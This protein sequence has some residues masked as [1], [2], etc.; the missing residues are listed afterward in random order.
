MVKEGAAKGMSIKDIRSACRPYIQEPDDGRVYNMVKKEYYKVTR[1]NS[2]GRPVGPDGAARLKK[3]RDG[4]PYAPK[5]PDEIRERSRQK[6]NTSTDPLGNPIGHKPAPSASTGVTSV[7]FRDNGDTLY[8]GFIELLDGKVVTPEA[9]MG[10]CNAAPER[11]VVQSFTVNMWQ[12]MTR[13]GDGNGKMNLWQF[14]IVLR[15]KKDEELTLDEVA[16]AFA[17]LAKTGVTP[18]HLP[19]I[20]TPKQKRKHRM[21]E[22]NLADLH[23]A[24]LSWDPECGE[25]YDYKIARN[26]FYQIINAEVERLK[27]GNFEKVLFVWTNDF[28]NS[29]NPEATTTAGT[30]QSTDIRHQK[31]F[32]KGMEMIVTAIEMLQQ[33]APVETFY[34]ASNHGRLTEWFGIT[35]LSSWFRNSKRVKVDLTCRA[36]HYIRYGVNLIGFSHSSYEKKQNLP[37]LMSIEVPGL[38]SQTTYREFHLAHIHSE[39]VE[40]KGG[41]VFRWL[42][43]VTATDTWHYDSGF[44]GAHKRSYSFVWDKNKGLES[45]NAVHVKT[46]KESK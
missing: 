5:N 12:G 31:M 37:H 25:N 45:I 35:Y 41:I 7:K 33:Y 10:V 46:V 1:G 43:S 8:E 38:W 44:V 24:K 4:K 28:F 15:P 26:Y 40:E 20:Q 16:E 34:I 19:V 13:E 9:V 23:F 30:Q 2:D 39:K 6:L 14:K 36:R 17:K 21:L 27:T 3:T 32:L 18:V 29:D 11:W 22:I 42:P